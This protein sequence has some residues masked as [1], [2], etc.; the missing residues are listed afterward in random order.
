[1]IDYDLQIDIIVEVGNRTV[2]V[3]IRIASFLHWEEW[4]LRNRHG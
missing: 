3:N 1:M 4:N 2:E